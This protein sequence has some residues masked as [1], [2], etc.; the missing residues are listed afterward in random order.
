M[1]KILIVLSIFLTMSLAAEEFAVVQNEHVDL[2][3]REGKS[4]VRLQRGAVVKVRTHSS[5]Q[6]YYTVFMGDKSYAAPKNSFRQVTSVFQE[7]RRLLDHIDNTR[8]KL[9]QLK[10]EMNE[11]TEKNSVT[12]KRISELQIWIEVQRDL[13]YSKDFFIQKTRGSVLELKELKKESQVREKALEELKDKILQENDRL[14]AFQSS[15][16]TLQTKLG[17]LKNERAFSTQSLV[18]VKVIASDAPVFFNGRVV[19][20]LRRYTTIKVRKHQSLEGWYVFYKNRKAHFISSSD[21][22][23]SHS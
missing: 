22:M 2:I 21:V 18:E 6:A 4:K 12:Q 8:N 11:L 23:V 1:K 13:S 5:D 3:N 15:F 7:E 20:Y 9:K 17:A 10:I 14:K 19:E 16:E